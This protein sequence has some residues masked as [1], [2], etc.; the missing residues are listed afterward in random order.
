MMLVLLLALLGQAV[1]LRDAFTQ[2]GSTLSHTLSHALSHA[3]QGLSQKLSIWAELGTGTGVGMR[4]G[5][6]QGGVDRIE[7]RSWTSS[8]GGRETRALLALSLSLSL[9]VGMGVGT[10]I[11]QAHAATAKVMEFKDLQRLR[12]GLREV[13]FLLDNWDDK[14]TYCNFAEFQREL[15]LPENKAKLMKAAAETG[16]LDYDKSATMNVKCRKDP[17]VVRAFL[18]LTPENTLLNK[19][20][21]L[22]K[23]PDVLERVDDLD[24]YFEAVETYTQAVTAADGLAYTART[25]YASQEV[26]SKEESRAEAGAG[27]RD[28]LAQSRESVV[29][30]RDSLRCIVELLHIK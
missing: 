8:Q 17:E 7:P 11:P 27:K 29:I 6:G 15:L 9:M 26:K 22:M 30:V 20:E 23:L 25:D 13:E 4:E 19:A 16:L 14:V 1:G 21:V 18:G 24:A 2:A 3:S 5:V 12:Y 28:Y 10:G